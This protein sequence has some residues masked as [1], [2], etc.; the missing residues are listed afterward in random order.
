R[1][2]LHRL[3]RRASQS[4]RH[5]H[6]AEAAHSS[7]RL[8]PAPTASP[9]RPPYRPSSRDAHKSSHTA[10]WLHTAP[11]PAQ[12]HRHQPTD[13][14]TSDAL[15]RSPPA[16]RPSA[17]L[18]TDNSRADA[19]TIPY[20]PYSLLAPESPPRPASPLLSRSI[21]PLIPTKSE[22][23]SAWSPSA[24]PPTHTRPSPLHQPTRT[25]IPPTDR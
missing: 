13:T 6:R 4:P 7:S 22:R 16:T 18:R 17:K 12:S 24:D 2:S 25:L 3:E 5:A 19:R 8:T 23:S 20:S 9:P 21:P 1:I 11:T 14:T 10:R 15:P